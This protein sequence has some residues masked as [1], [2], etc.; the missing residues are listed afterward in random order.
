MEFI[1][2]REFI[3]DGSEDIRRLASGFNRDNSELVLAGLPEPTPYIANA[4]TG[5]RS[6]VFAMDMRPPLW[7]SS[8]MLARNVLA[9]SD[10]PFDRLNDDAASLKPPNGSCERGPPNSSKPSPDCPYC[11]RKISD[12]SG[13]GIPGALNSLGPKFEGGRFSCNCCISGDSG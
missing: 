2:E 1:D 6:P 11:A 7:P 12:E 13:R 3:A 9:S 8:D 5:L 4:S 10:P